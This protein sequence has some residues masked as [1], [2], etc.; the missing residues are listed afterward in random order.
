MYHCCCNGRQ[1]VIV[2]ELDFSD[3]DGVVLVDNGNDAHVEE[4]RECILSI[5]VLSTLNI[6]QYSMLF[7]FSYG[8][9][10]QYHSW[11]VE[12]GQLVDG[13]DRTSCPR[14]L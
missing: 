4:L 10:R 12:F 6:R 8:L 1:R 9:H 14:D 3:G 5:E 7:L 2:S 13:D 11:S